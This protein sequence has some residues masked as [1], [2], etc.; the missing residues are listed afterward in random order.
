MPPHT[1]EVAV[2]K[3]GKGVFVVGDRERLADHVALARA[4]CNPRRVTVAWFLCELEGWGVLG[5]AAGCGV[6]GPCCDHAADDR[7][8]R[9]DSGGR[10]TIGA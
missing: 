6:A 7:D 10:C 9:V 8:D 4:R 2:A 1:N 3:V 5:K